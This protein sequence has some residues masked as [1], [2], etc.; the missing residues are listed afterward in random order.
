MRNLCIALVFVFTSLI[1][2]HSVSA[3]NDPSPAEVFALI[4]SYRASNG[5]YALE[6][7][8]ILMQTAQ[9]QSDYQASIS[10]VTHGGPGGSRPR[11][12]AYAAGYGAGA[13]VFISEL[14]TGGGSDQTPEGALNWWQNSPEHNGYLLSSN[15][16]DLG[17]GVATDA[18]GRYYYTAVLG[19]IAAGTTY[20]PEAGSPAITTPQAVMIPVVRA[21]PRENGAI[22]HIVRQ[23][24]ALWT[25]A[26]VYEIELEKLLQLN[27]LTT[28]SFIFPGD[29]IIVAP[30]GSV[31]P[32]QEEEPS[33]TL[34]EG[35]QPS[36]FATVVQTSAPTSQELAGV[37]TENDDPPSELVSISAQETEEQNNTVKW[38]I[39]LALASILAV[40]IASFFIQ[41]PRPLDQNDNDPFAPIE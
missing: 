18:E 6:Q 30:A 31:A 9:G 3:S 39:G 12:R 25:I 38:V 29:E 13:I 16:F 14:V 23:G 4:N 36:E 21:E 15:Y 17:V 1:A 33:P 28:F 32:A 27:N 24:Q 40:I 37:Q 20:V 5:L 8:S 22:V 35:P 10:Q 34:E 19:N 26:A 41:R 2:P 7:N 11:D